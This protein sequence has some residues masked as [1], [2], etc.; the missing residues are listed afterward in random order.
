MNFL[1]QTWS[2]SVP[3][4]SFGIAK[5][6]IFSLPPN[7]FAKIFT[8]TAKNRKNR[9]FFTAWSDFLLVFCR[10]WVLARRLEYVKA[11]SLVVNTRVMVHPAVTC[12]R[13]GRMFYKEIQYLYIKIIQ[14]WIKENSTA[15]CSS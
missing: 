8:K 6:D 15:A 10:F 14:L 9:S 7:F 13:H 4:F 11:V 12:E 1:H 2:V 5:V 3:R